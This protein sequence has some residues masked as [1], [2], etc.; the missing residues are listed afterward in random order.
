MNTATAAIDVVVSKIMESPFTTEGDR[1]M[2]LGFLDE[3]LTKCRA[4]VNK[5]TLKEAI[6]SVS[7]KVSGFSGSPLDM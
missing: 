3:A 4:D 6:N 7:V 5:K 2:T 1:L